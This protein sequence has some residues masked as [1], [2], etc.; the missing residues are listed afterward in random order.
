MLLRICCGPL[1]TSVYGLGI[2]SFNIVDPELEPN[3]YAKGIV[4]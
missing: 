2:M 4:S 1:G 3:E